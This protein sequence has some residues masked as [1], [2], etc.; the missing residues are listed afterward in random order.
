MS[1]TSLA[2]RLLA[3]AAL[4]SGHTVVLAQGDQELPTSA[5]LDV[6]VVTAQ[7]REQNLQEVPIAISAISSEKLQQLQITDTQDLTGLAPNLTVTQSTT[8][9]SAS[10]ISLRGI[11]SGSQ[12]TFGLDLANAV[13]IDGIY[14][15]RSSATGMGVMDIDRVEVLRGPQ[16]TLFGRNTTGG[17]ISFISREP[18]MN[19]RLAVEGGYGNYDAWNGR[20]S[21]DPGQMFGSL[22]TSFG[23][24]HSQRNGTID[25]LLEPRKSIDP[26]SYNSDAIRAAALAELADSGSIKYIFD[27]SRVS[28][29]PVKFQL[30]HVADGSF[31]PPLIIAGQE[32]VATQQAP[33]AGY[34]ANAIFLEPGCAELGIPSREYRDKICANSAAT[35]ID[36]TWGHN[37]QI[38]NDFDAF[39]VKMTAGYR[40]A[41]IVETGTDLDGIGTIKGPQFTEATF[42][43]GLPES[44]LQFILP[45]GDAAYLAGLTVPTTTQDFFSNYN[46]RKHKQFSTE[47]EISGDT[48]F[49]DWVVGGFYF[50]EKGSENDHQNSAFVLDTN[51]IFMEN[52]GPL[53]GA[54]VAENPA[55]YRAFVTLANLRYIATN[56][57]KAVYGQVTGYPGGR[58]GPLSLTVG[59]R[60]TWDNKNMM[61]LQN[62]EAPLAAIESGADS[63][64]KLTWNTMARYEF[65]LD[66][67]MYARAATGYRS[68]G[69]N[70]QDPAIAGTTT[71]GNFKPETVTS[72]EVGLK[73]E[74]FDRRVRFNIAGYYNEYDNLA[75]LIPVQDAPPGTF[76]TRIGNAGKVTYTGIEA[77]LQAALTDNFTI[78]GTIGYVDVK[79]KTFL[80]GQPTTPGAPPINIA[81]VVRPTYTAPMT[82][83]VA[84]NGRFP[85][86]AANAEMVGRIAYTHEDGR[87]NFASTIQSPFND[88][89]KSDARDVIDAQLS[90]EKLP[91]GGGEGRI[92]LWVKNLTNAHDFLRAID[93]AQLGYAGGYYGEPRTYGISVG[94]KF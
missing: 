75:V 54:F 89:L 52:F 24:A 2:I 32:V 71:L 58:D 30:T 37:L 4:I 31:N 28:G 3:S 76:A 57:S 1:T 11:S 23:Y 29:N 50:W 69:F 39:S 81:T 10:V 41:T 44:L 19:F 55:Q 43:N 21:V 60:Y 72:Y 61:R 36:K 79:T 25:N 45:A 38:Q 85:I 7:K 47:V 46:T 40:H 12:E 27:W 6:I 80:A 93:F 9:H 26:G 15:A 64:K 42:L 49:M 73:T 65:T 56:E 84:L 86:G 74:L 13:Y 77:D 33:V 88:L 62:G 68:G 67:S 53:G 87:Y 5:G 51:E 18:S 59:A 66:I 83:N 94:V 14:L 91:F 48:S 20:I 34:L 22:K 16:G 8:N 90:L 35:A 17:A 82:A 78:D 63:F 70:A 92:M